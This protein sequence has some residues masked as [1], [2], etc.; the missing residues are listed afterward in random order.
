MTLRYHA[1]VKRRHKRMHYCCE[2]SGSGDLTFEPDC[3]VWCDVDIPIDGDTEVQD[4]LQIVTDQFGRCLSNGVNASTPTGMVCNDQTN[5][6]QPR[7]AATITS[8]SSRGMRSSEAT[9]T[10]PFSESSDNWAAAAT[11]TGQ[12]KTVGFLGILFA[13]GAIGGAL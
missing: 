5:Y 7:A 3:Y 4:A 10:V 2:Q 6:T 9:S 1:N 12:A 13:A 8:T 11:Q